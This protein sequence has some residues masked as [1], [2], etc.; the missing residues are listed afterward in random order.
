MARAISKKKAK[1]VAHRDRLSNKDAMIED[2]SNRQRKKQLREAKL[3]KLTA[4][5]TPKSFN[6]SAEGTTLGDSLS[7]TMWF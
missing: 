4:E 5:S 3:A 2:V 6:T 7:H 1:K